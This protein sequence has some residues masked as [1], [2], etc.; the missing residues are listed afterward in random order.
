ME[1]KHRKRLVFLDSARGFFTI[2]IILA[3]SFSHLMF[4]DMELIPLEDVSI[5]LVI[6]LAPV[7]ILATCAP[8]FVQISAIALSYNVLLDVKEYITTKNEST[9]NLK[10]RTQ[11]SFKDPKLRRIVKKNLINYTVLLGASLVHVF[12][13]HYGLNWNDRIQRT[14]LTG[15]LETGGLSLDFEVFFQTDAIGLIAF[16]GLFNVGLL[17]LL[18]RKDGYYKP[19]RNLCI[20]LGIICTWFILSPL[21][22]SALDNVFW[23]SLNN[24][25]YGL[26]FL[27][28]F[29]VGPPMSIFPNF[30]YGFTG[31]IIGMG[32]AQ[33]MKHTFFRKLA[34]YLSVI[35]I[36]AA[37][38]LILINGFTLSPESFGLFLPIEIQALDF[39]V[40][41]IMLLIFI[42]VIAFSKKSKPHIKQKTRFWKRFGRITMTVYIFESVLCIINM[43]WFVPLWQM[44][45]QT[46]FILHLE[47]F[48]FMGMQLALWYIIILLW[49]KK[50]FR[51]SV[52][53]FMIIIRKKLMI[54][55]SPKNETIESTE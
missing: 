7:V 33:E 11:I 38:L 2:I 9:R 41:Q 55:A 27:L 14:L 35:F 28:K 36:G 26:T 21:L 46:P 6:I 15:I 12:L 52:E 22:H 18:L 53:W 50:N 31:L 24:K 40:V 25:Q 44:L 17:I 51:Y 23:A 19:V 20:L 54:R 32:F 13:F 3:H 34:I 29:I 16:S 10:A 42:V 37:G 1:R 43:I 47:L 39:A 30:A 8:V 45:P 5:I 48:V 4:W 49:E